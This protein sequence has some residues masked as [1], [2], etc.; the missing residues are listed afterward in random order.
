[1]VWRGY[2]LK[3]PPMQGREVARIRENLAGKF[4]WARDM[5]VT[6]GD[7]YDQATAAAVEEFQRRVGLPATGIADFATHGRLGAWPPPPPPRHAGLTFRGTGGIVGLD[8]TSRVAQEAG[9]DEIPILYPGSMGGIPV[10]AENN[11]N[12]P[13]GNDSVATARE[14]AIDWIESNPTRLD[15]VEPDQDVL[16]A[17]LFARRDR[18]QYGAR[19]ASDGRTAGAVRR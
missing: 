3:D 9:L 15:R 13:S 14:M 10:G 1:M 17:W 18:R 8:Y 12:A 5:G 19:G 16:P 4:R 7:V 11:P 6:E 2:E